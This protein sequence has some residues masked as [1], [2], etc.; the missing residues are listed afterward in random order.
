MEG[1]AFASA[2]RPVYSLLLDGGVLDFSLRQESKG[3]HARDKL[4]ERIALAFLWGDEEL[5][6]PRFSYLFECN[7][8]D[9]LEQ[10]ASFFWR[11]SN[12]ELSPTQVERIFS[13]WNQCV[14]RIRAVTNTPPAKLLSKLGRL[15]CFMKVV[16]DRERD[17]LLAVAPYVHV[18][19]NVDYFIEELDRLVE[20][21][22][23]NISV[24]LGSVL[25]TF[26]PTFD[27]QDRLKSLILKLSRLGQLNE[28]IFY[29]NQL[30]HLPGMAHLFSE[31]TEGSA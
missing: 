6:G 5:N 19:H 15:S 2:T 11:V 16:E 31:L 1:L 26:A 23:D 29:A 7:R 28:A 27:F 13:F 25:E 3:R 22:P 24:V 8:I 21:S 30:R 9:D 20:V 10:V 14:S 12:Q 17:W 4:L 18:E